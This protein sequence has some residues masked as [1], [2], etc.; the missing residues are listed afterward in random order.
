MEFIKKD[1]LESIGEKRYKHSLRV[2]ETSLELAERYKVDRGKVRIASLLHDCGKIKNKLK[3]I[4]TAKKFDIVLDEYMSRNHELI[5][6]PLG[7]KIAEEKYNIRDREIID[8]IK[9]HT[10]GRKNMTL[11]DKIVYISDYIEPGRKFKGV[12]EIREIAYIDLDK[13]IIMAMNSSIKFLI[14]N[15][16][17]I[18]IDT[19]I[20]RNDLIIKHMEREV[21]RC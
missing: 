20:A 8:A 4:E 13:S 15:G 1:I 5:H 18:N 2:M 9:Y 19:I 12:E 16:N 21:Y 10:T 14:K 6:G 7:A 11:L 17:L 3:L